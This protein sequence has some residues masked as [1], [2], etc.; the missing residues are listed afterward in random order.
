LVSDIL[1]GDGKTAIPYL[2]CSRANV[3][4]Y[5]THNFYLSC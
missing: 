1:A 3:Q 4:I 5:K 2:Q